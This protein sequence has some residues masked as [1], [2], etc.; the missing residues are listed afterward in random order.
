MAG[1]T[2]M[3]AKLNLLQQAVRDDVTRQAVSAGSRVILAAMASRAPVLDLKTAKSTAL[4]PGVLKSSMRISVKKLRD[5]YFRALIGPR[6]NVQF[7]A[8]WVEYG[9]RLVKGGQSK[10]TAKGLRG[11]GREVGSV[12][13]HPFLRPAVDESE[14]AAL[15]V[16][17]SKLK[18]GL[19]KVLQP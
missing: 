4:D 15:A 19:R 7:V 11:A 16:F 2:Q 14:A 10:V 5:G 6:E 3:Q 18:E 8:H 12:A 17:A 9:H 13:A 1:I